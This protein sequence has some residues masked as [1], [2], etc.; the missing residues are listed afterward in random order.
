MISLFFFKRSIVG[1]K[2]VEFLEIVIKH[3]DKAIDTFFGGE[4]NMG[5]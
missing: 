4:G 5:H 3:L 1:Y 2:W